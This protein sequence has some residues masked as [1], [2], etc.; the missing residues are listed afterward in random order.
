M[1]LRSGVVNMVEQCLHN[2]FQQHA[3]VPG[4][5]S[6]EIHRENLK[7]FES[8]WPAIQSSSTCLSCLRR[9]PQYALPCG[10]FVCDNRVQIFGESSPDDP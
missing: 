10:H 6:A 5:A 8:R 7:R 3:E 2:L 9:R 4:K 1:I